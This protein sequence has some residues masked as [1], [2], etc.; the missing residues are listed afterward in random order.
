MLRSFSFSRIS[1]AKTRS[2]QVGNSHNRQ[3]CKYNL[4][5]YARN[6]RMKSPLHVTPLVTV[7]AMQLFRLIFFLSGRQR[8]EIPP[9]RGYCII[10]PSYRWNVTVTLSLNNLVR[11][12]SM[13]FHWRRLHR[14]RG[15][16]PPLLQMAGHVGTLSR[17]TANKKLTKLYWPSQLKRSPKQLIVHVEPKK[18]SGTTKNLRRTCP[19]PTFNFLP[20]SVSTSWFSLR[21]YKVN[22]YKSENGFYYRCMQ[23]W[24]CM[25]HT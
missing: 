11:N 4:S 12:H 3:Y 6:P 13:Y 21:F 15:H 20:A 17:G 24:I 9:Q 1:N 14:A 7:V 23:T 25:K 8:G 19:P 2:F 5:L 22:F 16:V 18:W 10:S